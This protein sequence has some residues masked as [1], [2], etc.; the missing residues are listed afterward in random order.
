MKR[1]RD[2]LIQ[3]IVLAF[4]VGAM[5]LACAADFTVDQVRELLAKADR[6]RP[7]DLTG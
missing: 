3:V 2:H 6:D 7:A 5:R 4:A 1:C